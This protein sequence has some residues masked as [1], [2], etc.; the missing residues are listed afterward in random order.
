MGGT[1]ITRITEPL[2][3]GSED[4]SA[5][6]DDKLRSDRLK[7]RKLHKVLIVGASNSG[8]TTLFFS[9]T[10]LK[11]F[12]SSINLLDLEITRTAIPWIQDF[13]ICGIKNLIKYYLN[14]KI[15]PNY[16]RI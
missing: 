15:Q 14:P 5:L 2:V 11:D 8:R 10:Q 7:H 4:P 12:S 1:G 16:G 6:I 3:V 9:L 13:V